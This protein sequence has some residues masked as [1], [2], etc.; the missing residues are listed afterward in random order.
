MNQIT[1]P[2]GIFLKV[3]VLWSVFK[4]L[5]KPFSDFLVPAS[6]PVD[7]I[8][9]FVVNYFNSYLYGSVWSD[10]WLLS[11]G[12][13]VLH[14]YLISKV[15]LRNQVYWHDERDRK[16]VW[17]LFISS[18]FTIW[19]EPFVSP[20]QLFITIFLGPALA[21]LFLF[22][23]FF[24]VT[25]FFAHPILLSSLEKASHEN[26]QNLNSQDFT[27]VSPMVAGLMSLI[28][29]GAGQ[30]Y[31]GQVRKGITLICIT[32]ALRYISSSEILNYFVPSPNT[33][34]MLISGIFWAID[35]FLL[36]KSCQD[37]KLENWEFGVKQFLV[38]GYGAFIA[39]L[40]LT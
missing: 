9:A 19:A 36:A 23:I 30:I 27:E 12:S 21:F 8:I 28:M 38:F 17:F 40:V 3:W 39:T 33:L 16:I 32:M 29:S 1:L 6:S 14:I 20:Q 5:G 26:N 4:C 22:D 37:R 24:T 25:R 13:I 2:K 18:L 35:A 31:L 7:K 10:F 15:V 11:Y 34:I